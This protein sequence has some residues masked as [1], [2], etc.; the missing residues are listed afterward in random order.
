[1][2]TILSYGLA[3]ILTDKGPFIL[4][5]IY[6]DEDVT[7]GYSINNWPAI[8]NLEISLYYKYNVAF[9]EFTTD[10]FKIKPFD[11][12]RVGLYD[13]NDNI[14]YAYT[15]PNSS[16]PIV[17]FGIAIFGA[18]NSKRL[19]FM[20]SDFGNSN[21]GE[22]YQIIA[23]NTSTAFGTFKITQYPATS[24][25][26]G[27]AGTQ[28]ALILQDII[29]GAPPTFHWT[30]WDQINGNNGRYRCNLTMIKDESIGDFTTQYISGDSSYF[31]RISSQSDIWGVFQ[32]MN[33]DV[34][35]TIAYS[36][37]AYLTLTASVV[38]GLPTHANFTYKFYSNTGTLLYTLVKEVSYTGGAPL[39]AL[40]LSFVYDNEMQSAVFLPVEKSGS[41]Y[42]WGNHNPSDT[43]MLYIW[44]WLQMSGAGEDERP[45]DTGTT[46]NGGQPTDDILTNDDMPSVTL[47]TISAM[48]SK[49]FT[50]YCPSD[51]DLE[52]I[53]DYLWSTNVID[54]FKKYFNNFSEN[55][56]ALYVLPYKPSNLPTKAFT[57]GGLTSE[58]I[59]AVEY[60]Q[61][62]FVKLDMGEVNVGDVWDS[63]LDFAPYT[64]FNIYLP[65]I[66]VQ[67]LDADDIMAPLDKNKNF[68]AKLGS[69]ISLEYAIDLMTGICV[70]V[71]KINGQ[72]RYQFSGKLGF[73]IPLTGENYN[74]I[75]HAFCVSGTG[76]VSTL[77]TG[78]AAAP[79]AATSAVTAITNAM[80][81][82]VY[83]GGNLTGNASALS[84]PT[85]YLIRRIPNKPELVN[86]DKFTGFQ[87]YKS[88]KLKDFGG[89][90]EVVEVHAEGFV[91][92]EEE[93][94]EIIELLKRGVIL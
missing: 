64:R 91:C 76:L 33:F 2:S 87:S 25:S 38:S 43:E 66:G 31:D 10:H 8:S 89:Y 90:T 79:F 41:L 24:S 71:V 51:Q 19:G 20:F 13:L 46:D 36:G 9:T 65:G 42:G 50:L 84:Y 78:G 70:A 94:T 74:S 16:S 4:P 81:P 15:S 75:L 28:E 56:I 82:D 35:T 69:K 23:N 32:N 3:H 12:S 34:E 39:D 11:T 27:R 83:R 6:V 48:Q 17:T 55:L 54:N 58:T 53:A 18:N 37:N 14:L 73:Q 30:A 61:Q 52:D 86:Q 45:Y 85:P 26:S 40:Y 88:G 77:A 57:V 93:R 80:K 62:R 60:I 21:W 47:P 1:M 29:E 5:A 7:S 68:G 59:T 44:Q 67:A 92:T 72:I 49:M 22:Q 63:Y